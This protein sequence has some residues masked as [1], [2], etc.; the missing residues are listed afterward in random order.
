MSGLHDRRAGSEGRP[1]H[2]LNQFGIFKNIV[3]KFGHGIWCV[4][5]G[6]KTAVIWNIFIHGGVSINNREATGDGFEDGHTLGV[7]TVRIDD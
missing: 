7:K 1:T 3:K 5:F 4:V 2:G 6:T